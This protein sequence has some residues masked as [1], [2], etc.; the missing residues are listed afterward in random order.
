MVEGRLTDWVWSVAILQW[1]PATGCYRS[2]WM[3]SWHHPQHEN[4]NW[5]QERTR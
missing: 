3:G 4:R 1:V 5:C 2:D